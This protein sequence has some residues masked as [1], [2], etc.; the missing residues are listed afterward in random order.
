L[1]EERGGRRLTETGAERIQRLERELAEARSAGASDSEGALRASIA[2]DEAERALVDSER[3]Y[4]RLVESSTD[5]VCISDGEVMTYVSPAVEGVLGFAAE[6]LR[7]TALVDLLEYEDRAEGLRLRAEV[8]AAPDHAPVHTKL[9]IR[10]QDGGI[11]Y[12]ALVFRNLFAE[13]T[14][15]GLVINFH[16]VTV[17]EQALDELRR[18]EAILRENRATLERAQAIAH[19]GSWTFAVDGPEVLVSSSEE[20]LRI[21]GIDPASFDG[22]VAALERCFAP[23]EWARAEAA[24]QP[25]LASGGS[26]T[27]DVR[28][29]RGDGFAWI[30]VE[31]VAEKALDGTMRVLGTSLDITDR[32]RAEEG[33]RASEARYRRII[34]TAS[35]GVWLTDRQQCTT[36]VNRR[37]A[38]M[39][40][41]APEEMTG[42][43]GSELT[44][45]PRPDGADNPDA[46]LMQAFGHI[47]CRLRRKDGTTCWVAMAT[48]R[49]DD[50]A[51]N[52]EGVLA[53]VTDIT[54]RRHAEELRT[55]ERLRAEL[56]E[57]ALREA[58][59]QL[60]QAQKLE[61]LGQLAGGVAHD[62]N[63]ILS[64]IL[65]YTSLLMEDLP[66]DG[67]AHADVSQIHEAGLRASDLTRQLLAFSRKQVPQPRA[68][69]LSLVVR[70]AE[71]LLRRLLGEDIEL[72]LV[73]APDQLTVSADPS[74]LEQVIVNLAVNARDAM[75]SGG[76][77]RIETCPAH[78]PAEETRAMG[79]E[80]GDYVSL[81]VTDSGVGM[82]ADVAARMFEPFFTTKDKGKGT[83]LGLSTVFGI[84]KQSAGHLIVD[85]A[86]GKGTEVRVLLP[87]TDAPAQAV[88]RVDTTDPPKPGAGETILLVEDED[89]VRLLARNVLRRC[90]YCVLEAA[91]PGEALLISEQHQGP[92]D[93]LL[94]D[95]VMPRMG[96]HQL[97]G[98]LTAGRPTMRV[99]FVSGYTDDTVLRHGV[100]LGQL[101]F[102][103]KPFTP[104]ALSGK[105]RDVLDAPPAA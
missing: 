66:R 82:T 13:P 28:I 54:E 60:R 43:P 21:L 32:V 39:L 76:R 86:P 78:L 72:V 80:P 5:V 95:V 73:Q 89:Q 84:V 44:E 93:L 15:R 59:E 75:P 70:R 45:E 83:G 62:F 3:R 33:L 88:D 64:V 58:E 56:A 7:G 1:V 57:R 61:A 31:G 74:Q 41:Y 104:N 97:A 79:L 36:F 90:G 2:R 24:I 100:G 81:S 63:N 94:T 69:D 11:R 9:R 34:E 105:V 16:D 50:E 65:G 26:F 98:R 40:G 47:E 38:E 10:H 87:A 92:I 4:K 37:M 49:L 77:L 25:T 12:V 14:I 68:V 22:S 102:L 91:N 103:A 27:Y 96:G 42:K 8:L 53:M 101:A 18:S 23:G 17:Q 19:I 51:G 30:H 67:G 35:E 99:L 55:R 46:R 71:K 6:D 85:S 29:H 48:S 52:Y 20:A